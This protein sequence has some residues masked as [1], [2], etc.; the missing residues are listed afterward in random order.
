MYKMR[1]L[2]VPIVLGCCEGSILHKRTL[3]QNLAHNPKS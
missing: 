1:I 3:E 2:I